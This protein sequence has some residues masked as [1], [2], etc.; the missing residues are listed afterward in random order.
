MKDNLEKSFHLIKDNF[1]HLMSLYEQKRSE[2]IK[3]ISENEQ[4][5]KDN[6]NYLEQI[7]N[8]T[9]QISSKNLENAFLSTSNSKEEAKNIIE[10]LIKEIDSCIG[11]LS[12]TK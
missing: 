3:L 7:E 10:Q 1:T 9:K 8:L 2:N 4:L 11:L 12:K 6:K 5:K